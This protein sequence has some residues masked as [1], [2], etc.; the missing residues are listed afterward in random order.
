[1]GRTIAAPCLLISSASSSQTQRGRN[2]AAPDDKMAVNEGT[3][4]RAALVIALSAFVIT[5]GQLLQQLFATS[6]G[7][8]RFD[9]SVI[10]RWS[11]LVRLRFRWWVI[12]STT[13]IRWTAVSCLLF[14]EERVPNAGS[15]VISNLEIIANLEKINLPLHL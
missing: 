2:I 8:R 7:L 15:T 14:D 11:Q 4:A 3:V 9:E 6:D 13:C 5:C 1:M 10:G 12:T